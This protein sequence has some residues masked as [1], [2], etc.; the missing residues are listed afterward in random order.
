MDRMRFLSWTDARGPAPHY[1]RCVVR[2]SPSDSKVT[3]AAWRA[4][5][6]AYLGWMLDGFDFTMLTFVLVDIAHTFTINSALAGA[7]GTVT[8]VFRL[9]GGISAGAAAD[10]WGRKWPLVLSIFWYSA[11]AFLSGFSPTYG[12]LFALRAL[13]GIGMGG[14]WTAGM[15]L[16]IEHWPPALR[17]RVSGMLQSGY[18]TG[19]MLAAF[20]VHFGAP[21]VPDAELRWRSLLWL[22]L[23]PS[24]L[25]LWTLKQVDESP[26]WLARRAQG[27][28]T[29][30]RGG[31]ARLFQRDLLPTTLH[32]SIVTSAFLCLY[33]AITFWYPTHVAAQ[34]RT[35]LPFLVLLN[36]GTMIGNL[37]W[38]T[39]SETRAGRRGAATISTT[40]AV[41]AI[42]IYLFSTDSRVLL[43]G[44]LVTGIFG[45]G[46]FGLV[47]GY[48]NERF[49][50]TVRALGAGFTYHVGAAVASFMPLAIG[51]LVDGGMPLA[52]AMAI[53]MAGSGS[54]IVITIWLGP[55]TR[56]RSLT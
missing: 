43:L 31:F 48:L 12:V 54:L 4:F 7:L 25:A 14:V 40:G 41:L 45:A 17:G 29:G 20:V 55:E 21:L 56:G 50:T 13:F 51:A 8:L 22:G 36:L 27:G 1:T 28:E 9:V 35:S 18:S 5:T 15:P 49:P 16:A 33:Y 47:P 53:C 11:F 10:R 26:V 32:A 52:R 44:A 37:V 30:T 38:G 6:A 34:G 23:L 46:N 3:P 24:L 39:L 19:F 42:P 2:A